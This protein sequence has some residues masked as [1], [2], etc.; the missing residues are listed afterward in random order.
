M[1]SSLYTSL[2]LLVLGLSSCQDVVDLDLENQ[3]NSISVVGT[4]TDTRG[5]QV[6]LRRTAGY[7]DQGE[8]P[9]I[10]D[11]VVVVYENDVALDTLTHDDDEPGKYRSR[12][13]GSIGNSYHVEILLSEEVNL[14]GRWVSTPVSMSRTID[15]SKFEIGYLDRNTIPQVFTPGSYALLH[16]K[17]PEGRGDQYRIRRWLNDTLFTNEVI[18]FDDNEIDGGDFGNQFPPFNIYGPFSDTGAVMRVEARSIS[19]EHF[20]YLSLLSEQVYQVGGPFDPP[21]SPIIGNIYNAADPDEYGY[22]FFDAS[23]LVQE[24]VT[25]DP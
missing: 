2:F 24:S 17:E 13:N 15:I 7:F 3:V 23:A 4:V 19:A 25:F 9:A 6:E 12:F 11:A 22:G 14:P 1:K 10:S 5:T 20:E 21:P 18:I 16:F 8:T